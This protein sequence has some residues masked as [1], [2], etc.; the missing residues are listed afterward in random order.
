ML[1]QVGRS[2]LLPLSKPATEK[3]LAT[4]CPTAVPNSPGEP[5]FG[6][7]LANSVRYGPVVGDLFLKL[8]QIG[9]KPNQFRPT[10]DHVGQ[11][12]ANICQALA[13]ICQSC[14]SLGRI[15]AVDV[16]LGATVGHLDNVGARRDRPEMWSSPAQTLVDQNLAGTRTA[17]ARA[18]FVRL[19]GAWRV[20]GWYTVGVENHR[21]SERLV[22]DISFESPLVR[23]HLR[24]IV[25]L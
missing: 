16:T 25:V 5:R 18:K 20:P 14:P 17:R 22:F 21:C 24:N 11:S 7:H 8:N 15:S 23:T 12:L 1:P 13:H 6:P 19:P 10:L 2:F 9:P 4:S 3:V